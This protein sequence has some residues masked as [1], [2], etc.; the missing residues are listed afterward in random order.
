MPLQCN[1]VNNNNVSDITD[2]NI[3]YGPIDKDLPGQYWLIQQVCASGNY[4]IRS[5]VKQNLCITAIREDKISLDL[6]GSQ[7]KSIHCI[8]LS[9]IDLIDTTKISPSKLWI[10]KDPI[11]IIEKVCTEIPTI[12]PVPTK[13]PIDKKYIIIGIA[14]FAIL[15]ILLIIFMRKKSKTSKTLNTSKKSHSITSLHDD[16]DENDENDE[17]DNNDENDE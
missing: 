6:N 17:N 2:L 8:Y 4:I 13:K 9:P 14:I 1:V 10:F 11:D 5:Q 16:Y 12:P 3:Y 7:F 15:I